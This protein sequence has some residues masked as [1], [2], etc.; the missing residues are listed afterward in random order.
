MGI[1][2]SLFLIALGA[3]LVF[4]L[5]IPSPTWINLDVIGWV[6]MAVG[7]IGAIL[8]LAI[9]GRRRT[10]IVRDRRPTLTEDRDVY[11]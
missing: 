4:G 6:M 8:T 3:I 1:G 11:P 9:W 7:L 10:T 2:A 5:D